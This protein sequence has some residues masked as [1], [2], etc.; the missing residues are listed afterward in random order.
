VQTERHAALDCYRAQF[1]DADLV[2]LHT[3]MDRYERG[4]ATD[5]T[6]DGRLDGATHAEVFRI[7]PT[8]ALHVGLARRR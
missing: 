7:V 6:I 1:S 5:A 2:G 4:N 8:S 3:A